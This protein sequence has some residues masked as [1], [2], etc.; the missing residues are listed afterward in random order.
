MPILRSYNTLSRSAAAGLCGPAQAT[1][2]IPSLSARE[3]E[4]ESEREREGGMLRAPLPSL[5]LAL[6]LSLS[7]SLSLFY[8]SYNEHSFFKD[9][10]ETQAPGPLKRSQAPG[11]VSAPQATASPS[12][13]GA[14]R[15][16][17]EPQRRRILRLR[18]G[19][20]LRCRWAEERISTLSPTLRP[21]L[22]PTL[23]IVLSLSLGLLINFLT[24]LARATH[25]KW[26]SRP[27]R[28]PCE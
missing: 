17:G 4:S 3:R 10:Y 25:E 28:P 1:S 16:R 22:G 15:E 13:Q 18:R 7:F 11:P 5:S 8:Q 9:N 23:D 24:P 6:S 12:L 19:V 20:D 27:C 2:T 26:D 14:W 21:T